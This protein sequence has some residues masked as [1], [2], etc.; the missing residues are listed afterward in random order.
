[1]GETETDRP[2][3]ET[4]PPLSTM[5]DLDDLGDDTFT[6]H[7]AS[8][9]RSGRV[10]GGEVAAQA[11]MAA[12]HTVPDDRYVHSLH[13]YFLLGGNPDLPIRYDVD[14]TRDG[15]SFTTR[16]IQAV[17]DDAVIFVMAASFHREEE[18]FT[19]QV[20]VLDTPPPDECATAE[21][22][23]EQADERTSAWLVGL[24]RQMPWEVRFPREPARFTAMDGREDVAPW[25]Q[26]WIRTTDDGLTTPAQH[27]A[28]LAHAS[29]L[30]LL[31]AALL[32][33]AV[34][35]GMHQ[36]Q[37]ASLDHTIWFHRQPR[38]D[39]WL[40]YDNE[41]TWAGGARALCRGRFFDVDGNLVATVAQEGLVR[42]RDDR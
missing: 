33:H 27:A 42:I 2:T 37:A 26:T 22:M 23:A 29:D 31:G 21:E 24:S 28:A 9:R 32:P 18:G 15:G 5:L 16:R 6:R 1:M 38:V 36:L 14:R 40:L 25:Q 7:P 39:Q 41:S 4:W 3:S 10:F 13:S 12:E 35:F 11:L 34:H 17:Q 30:F 20:P 8:G 19:H